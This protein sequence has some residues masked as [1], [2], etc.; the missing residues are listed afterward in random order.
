MVCNYNATEA[1]PDCLRNDGIVPVCSQECPRLGYDDD[2][3]N[4][5]TGPASLVPGAWVQ[6]R[7]TLDHG[8]IIGITS[9]EWRYNK[10]RNIM[11]E[12]I[13]PALHAMLPPL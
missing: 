1:E 3:R 8:A 5:Y 7:H 10:S 2:C 13:S 6:Y 9:N 12:V 4:N 11:E